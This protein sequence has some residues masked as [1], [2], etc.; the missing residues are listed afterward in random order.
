M[1][2]KMELLFFLSYMGVSQLTRGE[3]GIAEQVSLPYK[4]G[5]DYIENLS[6]ELKLGEIKRVSG[7]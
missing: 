1:I 2:D 6:L 3:E 4:E 7:D 5:I